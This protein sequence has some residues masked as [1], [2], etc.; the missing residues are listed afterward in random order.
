[1]LVPDRGPS[2]PVDVLTALCGQSGALAGM[3]Q[4]LRG[5]RVDLSPSSSDLW[6]GDAE[7]AQ[8]AYLT[9]FG[10]ILDAACSSLDSAKRHTD[11]A[12]W[13]VIDVG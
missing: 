6:R 9:Q 4:R 12:I 1:M 11:A 5:A 13:G 2:V 10:S 8:A 7:R 3:L